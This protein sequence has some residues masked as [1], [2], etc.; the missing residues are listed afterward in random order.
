[1]MRSL[2][3][4]ASSLLI[5][6]CFSSCIRDRKEEEE[7]KLNKMKT[8]VVQLKAEI[9]QLEAKIK[10]YKPVNE[11][12]QEEL[13]NLGSRKMKLEAEITDNDLSLIQI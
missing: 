2:L 3:L 12:W 5:L 4:I 10:E 7:V 11:N 1:M 8:E 9:A 13:N 6:G